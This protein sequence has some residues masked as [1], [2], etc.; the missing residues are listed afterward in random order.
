MADPP[1]ARRRKRN[2][3]PVPPTASAVIADGVRAAI[4]SGEYAP[5]SRIGQESIGSQYGVSRLPVREALRELESEG[6]VTL[7]PHSGARVAHFDVAECVEI[8]KLREAVEPLLIADASPRLDD[9]A[10]DEIRGLAQKVA[11]CGDDLPRWLALDREF[12][13]A[14]LRHT[15]MLRGLDLIVRLWNQTQH[16]R[17]AHVSEMAPEQ[18]QVIHMEHA[19]IVDALARR[20]A[21]DAAERV[22]M[23]IRRTRVILMRRAE[24]DPNFLE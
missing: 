2:K 10:L 6:L 8:Y 4:L 19:L 23:H 21:A 18:L 16:F 24:L 22:R 14:T 3:R 9:A 20:D 11:D 12:H 13:L 7:I 1:P 17:R 5:G 15:H